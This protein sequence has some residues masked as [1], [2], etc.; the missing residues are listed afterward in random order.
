VRP[1]TKP[2]AALLLALV[3]SFMASSAPAQDKLRRVGILSPVSQSDADTRAQFGV[4]TERLREL[5]YVEGKNIVYE[6]AYAEGKYERLPVLAG[7]LVKAGAEV[8]VTHGTPATTAAKRATATLPIVAASFGDPVASGFA[9]S[10]AKPG[11]NITGFSTMGSMVY[12][13]RLELLLEAVPGAKR[14]GLMVNPDNSFYTR[15]LP[16]L[17][18]AAQ[19]QGRDLMVVNVK[20]AKTLQEGFSKLVTARVGG[21]LVGDDNYLSTQAGTIAGLAMKH[22]IPALFAQRRGVDEGGLLSYAN[23]SK[24]RYQS[25]AVYVDRILKGAKPAEM[26][27]EQPAR[28]ELFVNK[29]T[30]DALGLTLPPSLLTRAGKVIE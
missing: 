23:D 6:W 9:R 17:Q 11:G 1:A 7:E 14:I 20:D 5:G 30:A 21:V 4:F 2:R 25:A 22:K 29:K 27:I 3:V 19:K 24:F 13:K 8:I 16:G 12:E 18:S 26:P 10:L 15:V 28:F